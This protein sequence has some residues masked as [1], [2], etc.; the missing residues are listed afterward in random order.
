MRARKVRNFSFDTLQET[1]RLDVQFRKP[2]MEYL[3]RQAWDR[4]VTLGYFEPTAK[5]LQ[6]FDLVVQAEPPDFEHH[7]TPRDI[8]VQITTVQHPDPV[9]VITRGETIRGKRLDL[10]KMLT[11]FIA[12]NGDKVGFGTRGNPLYITQ[13]RS[14]LN[15]IIKLERPPTQRP[16]K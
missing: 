5:E 6:C 13:Y 12:C 11:P 8:T 3:R 9:F 15:A 14:V 10:N 16:S 7:S 2:E 1:S 4:L